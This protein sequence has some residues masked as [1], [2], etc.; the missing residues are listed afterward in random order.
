MRKI[1][2][3]GYL[4]AAWIFVYFVRSKE[5][6]FQTV[7]YE[8]NNGL[9]AADSPLEDVVEID[10]VLQAQGLQTQSI[11]HVATSEV[12]GAET[13]ASGGLKE[14]QSDKTQ[15]NG[16]D[17]L[18]NIPT[19]ED[20][21]SKSSE[22]NNINAVSTTP[23]RE[24]PKEDPVFLE[25]YNN[26]TA[27]RK[28]EGI[29][30]L[31]FL[32]RLANNLFEVAY[33]NNLAK[34][35][36]WKVLYR[37]A[38]DFELPNPRGKYCLPNA[39]LPEDHRILPE[40]QPHVLEDLGLNQ[41][42]WTEVLQNKQ[43]YRLWLRSL[44]SQGKAYVMEHQ[45]FPLQG[46]ATE[47]FIQRLNT[48]KSNIRVASMHAFFIHYDWMER[49]MTEIRHQLAVHPECCQHAPPTTDAVVFHVREFSNARNGGNIQYQEVFPKLIRHYNW[50]DRPIWVV[51]QPKSMNS[52][53]V[54]AIANATTSGNITIVPGVDQYDAFCTLTRAKTL[55]GS[56][57]SSYSQM[58]A[59]MMPPLEEG[60]DPAPEFHLPIP[61]LNPRVTVHG[62]TWKYHLVAKSKIDFEVYDV[63]HDQ[64]TFRQ[65]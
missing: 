59:L 11:Q 28:G 10:Q 65:A 34:S 63:P 53:I 12:D 48:Q 42:K 24:P 30:I 43:A 35:L 31:N 4:F 25:M 51:C 6:I 46:D 27:N 19:M 3:A 61:R 21:I 17:T 54:Q 2:V 49:R 50:T 13:T 60:G 64:I 55:V 44:A 29:I 38:W 33:A 9:N 22:N 18:N 7:H 45:K 15:N 52:S 40:L 37:Q 26:C 39:M 14:E 16:N 1:I 36:C 20:G 5:L 23:A 57:A 62:P 56:A 8:T 41:E 32:G 58:G 47:R